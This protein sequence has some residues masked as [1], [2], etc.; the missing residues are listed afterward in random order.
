MNITTTFIT[1]PRPES[2]NS[3]ISPR[4]VAHEQGAGDRN[5]RHGHYGA[6]LAPDEQAH[7]ERDDE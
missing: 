1:E 3:P 6:G 2:K 4:P 7:G 5:Q